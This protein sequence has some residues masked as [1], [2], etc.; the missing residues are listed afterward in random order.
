M[1]RRTRPDETDAADATETAEATT[2]TET[3]AASGRMHVRWTVGRKLG[4]LGGAGLLATLLVMG[5]GQY[6]IQ[7]L[8]NANEHQAVTAAAVRDGMRADMLHDALRA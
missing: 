2:P 8:K 1:F 4:A 7:T 6:A 5:T 3:D